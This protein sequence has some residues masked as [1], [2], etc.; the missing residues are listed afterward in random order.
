MPK[1]KRVW[2]SIKD[3]CKDIEPFV[4][5]FFLELSKYFW[6]IFG[7]ILTV[8]ILLSFAKLYYET[9][10]KLGDAIFFTILK[11]LSA[12][13]LS[14]IIGIA[15]V[16]LLFLI[17]AIILYPI[18]KRA[19][20]KTPTDIINNANANIP[21][22]T[23][24]GF[25]SEVSGKNRPLPPIDREKLGQYFKASFK[26]KGSID[27]FKLLLDMLEID[28]TGSS[29]NVGKVALLI[30]ESQIMANTKPNSFRKWIVIFFESLGL[31]CPK[32]KSKNKYRINMNNDND[33]KLKFKYNLYI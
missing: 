11:F 3:F 16:F 17:L 12:M 1:I 4:E 22:E 24:N 8:A 2:K 5:S 7:A 19:A 14:T 15:A 20:K 29:A 31:S 30:Y 21:S 27:R 26:Q 13:I 28:R 9:G 6:W 33:A 25:K 18:K 32:E 23:A 10:L